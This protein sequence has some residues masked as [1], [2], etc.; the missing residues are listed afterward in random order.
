[1]DVIVTI[2]ILLFGYPAFLILIQ[3]A[4]EFFSWLL[5]MCVWII[6]NLVEWVCDTIKKVKENV[7]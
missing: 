5:A 6:W 4:F 3:L 2:A 1:M 7:Q